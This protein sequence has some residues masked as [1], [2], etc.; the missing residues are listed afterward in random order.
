MGFNNNF[1]SAFHSSS[2][3]ASPRR[4]PSATPATRDGTGALGFVNAMKDLP[5]YTTAGG[6]LY[7]F[8][9]P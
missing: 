4:R 3:S 7:A 2:S 6:T 1:G 5:D 9:L 8:V